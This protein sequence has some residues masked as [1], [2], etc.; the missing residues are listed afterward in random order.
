M[1]VV[2]YQEKNDGLGMGEVVNKQGI[3]RQDI[4]KKHSQVYGRILEDF[5]LRQQ[6]LPML[7]TAGLITQEQDPN[8]R[9]RVLV[10]PTTELSSGSNN[11]VSEAG[12]D[13]VN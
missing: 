5:R 6:I 13:V 1:I 2:A 10:F 12:E 7:E 9:R 3:S 4:F 8:N 11:I